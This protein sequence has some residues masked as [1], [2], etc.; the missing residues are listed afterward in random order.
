MPVGTLRNII[1]PKQ[2][3]QASIYYTTHIHKGI[4]E[5]REHTAAVGGGV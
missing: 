5:V 3:S 4:P 1:I 2:S